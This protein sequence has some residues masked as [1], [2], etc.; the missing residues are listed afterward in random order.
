MWCLQFLIIA[1]VL[2]AFP[3]MKELQKHKFLFK[4]SNC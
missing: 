4:V 1:G 3:F 2:K